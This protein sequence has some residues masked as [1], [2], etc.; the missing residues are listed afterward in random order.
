MK[1]PLKITIHAV[2][3]YLNVVAF[4]L[5]CGWG[6]L[7]NASVFWQFTLIF[8]VIYALIFTAFALYYKNEETFLNK[9]LEEYKQQN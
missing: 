6:F 2:L 5:L 1:P 9:K 8:V 7:Q 4:S 3:S